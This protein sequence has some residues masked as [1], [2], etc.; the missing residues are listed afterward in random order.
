MLLGSRGRIG[1]AGPTTPGRRGL[2]DAQRHGQTSKGALKNTLTARRELE[3]HAWSLQF[4]RPCLV[5]QKHDGMSLN[6]NPSG[7]SLSSLGSRVWGLGF[8]V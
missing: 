6:L 7:M 3:G 4:W 1:L 8:R 2:G 5:Q